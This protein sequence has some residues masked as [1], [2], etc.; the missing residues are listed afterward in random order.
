MQWVLLIIRDSASVQLYGAR[1][2]EVVW[3]RWNRLLRAL[4]QEWLCMPESLHT[5]ATILVLE[6]WNWNVFYFSSTQ[7]GRILVLFGLE[8]PKVL[9]LSRG[10]PYC[11]WGPECI[12]FLNEGPPLLPK[13]RLENYLVFFSLEVH[14]TEDSFPMLIKYWP[15]ILHSLTNPCLALKNSVELEQGLFSSLHY[16]FSCTLKL[17]S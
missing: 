12:M 5:Q 15:R 7:K 3:F 16:K 10:D 9:Q 2:L 17:I 1:T 11:V 6:Q 8:T 4:Q 13:E 14:I